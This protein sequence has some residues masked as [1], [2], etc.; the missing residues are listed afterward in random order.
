MPARPGLLEN[1]AVGPVIVAKYLSPFEKLAALE[2]RLELLPG[3]EMVALPI[4][5][6]PARLAGGIGN[7][8]TSALERWPA[9]GDTSVDFP[10]PE[11]AEM[12]K[13]V[14]MRG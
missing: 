7:A 13:T 3:H 14:V 12:M 6:R 11:G 1:P 10:E 8:R 9:A 2:H 4:D 5:F